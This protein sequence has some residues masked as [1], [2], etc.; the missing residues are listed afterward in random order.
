MNDLSVGKDNG[1]TY[2]VS[3]EQLMKDSWMHDENRT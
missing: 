1:Q 3:I 2:I